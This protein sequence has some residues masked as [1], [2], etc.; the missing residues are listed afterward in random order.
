[1][2]LRSLNSVVVMFC[3]GFP[4]SG[5][6]IT[7][8]AGTNSLGPADG[9][10]ALQASIGP[11]LVT[12][13]PQGNI[14]FIDQ[15]T[16]VMKI[17]AQGMVSRFAGNGIRGYSGDGGPAI[18]A[19]LNGPSGIYADNSGNVFLADTANYRIRK[20]DSTGTITTIAGN[21]VDGVSPEGTIAVNASIGESYSVAED[22]LGNI[23]FA[24]SENNRIAKIDVHGLLTTAAGK[25]KSPGNSGDN[26]PATAAQL[27]YPLS[28]TVDPSNNIVI[29]D[30]S[31]NVIRV[32][33]TSGI[34]KTLAGTGKPGYSG[35]NGPATSAL[36]NQPWTVSAD[37]NGNILFV[38][39]DNDVIRRIDT[40]G[41][42]TTVA[43][44]AKA[45]LGTD[46]VSATSSS[47]YYPFG[48]AAEAGGSFLIADFSNNTI[49]RVST[50]G[51]I[52]TIAGNGFKTIS[53]NGGAASSAILAN[54]T[55]VAVDIN[56][57]LLIADWNN[58]LL[59]RV[60][61]A[62]GT[63]A[64]FARH[65]PRGLHGGQCP[66]QQR[67]SEFSRGNYDRPCGEHLPL[68]HLQRAHPQNRYQRHHHDHCRCRAIR[69]SRRRRPG[70]Q[71]QRE[72]SAGPAIRSGGKP[73]VRRFQQPRGPVHFPA[74]HHHHHCRH[75]NSRIQSRRRFRDSGAAEHP[76]RRLVR[77]GGESLHR[78]FRESQN[79]QGGPQQDHHHGRRHRHRRIFGRRRGHQRSAVYPVRHQFR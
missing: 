60:T 37:L 66:G 20:I 49:R 77:R 36:I 79:S 9:T 57:N 4:L 46:N 41:V 11:N 2:S 32:V 55:N 53:P 29:A 15:N 75:G 38:D 39:Y 51:I 50:S 65:R 22:S 44:N 8:L 61:L 59:E 71:S 54:P 52:T 17:S 18:N 47:L 26:G 13:D 6:V 40:K 21:G 68:R 74:R 70:A 48:V 1:M 43:G 19:S 33:N 14:Y 69:I 28:V 62:N 27:T 7:T 56:G 78:R 35:D 31:N 42:I 3:V 23:Y 10:P 64:A 76:D 25:A 73:G 24:D 16:L 34:I 72:R 12:A 30:T 5:Q 58:Q 67:R 45:G 63:I